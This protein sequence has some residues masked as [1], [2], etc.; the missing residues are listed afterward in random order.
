MLHYLILLEGKSFLIHRLNSWGGE[1]IGPTLGGGGKHTSDW[2]VLGGGAL[3]V[4]Q[5]QGHLLMTELS[6][7]KEPQPLAFS[8]CCFFPPS[9]HPVFSSHPNE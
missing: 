5:G 9:L 1:E 8:F 6:A 3:L 2:V 7:A 4:L